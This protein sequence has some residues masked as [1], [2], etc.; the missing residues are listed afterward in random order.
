MNWEIKMTKE[1]Q[2]DVNVLVSRIKKEPELYKDKVGEYLN[3]FKENL[4]KEEGGGTETTGELVGQIN[5]I[6]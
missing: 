2:K 3:N 6:A 1:E 4:E 5:F